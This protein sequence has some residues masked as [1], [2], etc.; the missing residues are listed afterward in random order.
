MVAEPERDLPVYSVH[1]SLNDAGGDVFRCFKQADGSILFIL[2]D[3]VGHSVISSYAVAAFLGL[4]S[5][6]VAGYGSLSQLVRRLSHGIQ[7]GPFAQV[8]VCAALWNWTPATGRLH[9]LNAGLPHGLLAGPGGPRRIELNG[10]PLGIFE[11]PLVE[12][13]VLMLR[14]GDRV[15]LASD[16]IF[17]ARDGQ[18]RCFEDSALELWHSLRAALPVPEA[19]ARMA[20]AAREMTGGVVTDDLLA[21]GF[22]QPPFSAEGLRIEL[23]SD[24]EAIDEAINKLEECIHAAPRSIPLTRSRH[25]DILTSAREALTNAMTHGNGGDPSKGIVL[26]AGWTLEPPAFRLAVVDEGLGF[27][28]DHLAPLEDPLAERGRGV[29]FIRHCANR[30]A[31]VGGELEAVFEW[32]A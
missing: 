16:G 22:E 3:V 32:E 24:P 21:V 23:R 18:G 11:E 1:Q 25:F 17:E 4:L 26:S 27:E 2:A 5:S 10:T 9:V 13:K 31:M 20:D 30:V 8:P 19:V 6:L 15:L 28:L 7:D 29:P 12:E 14:P